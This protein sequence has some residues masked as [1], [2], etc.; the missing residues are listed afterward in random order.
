MP[1]KDQPPTQFK[2]DLNAYTHYLDD[3]DIPEADK[4]ALIQTLWSLVTS[5]VQLGYGQTPA[6]QAMQTKNAACGQSPENQDS[7]AISDILLVEYSQASP[8][9]GDIT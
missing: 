1:D 6:Q 8:Q 7:G 3:A 2:F 5:F 9:K 4:R